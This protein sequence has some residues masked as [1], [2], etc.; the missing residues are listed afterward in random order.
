M[1]LLAVAVAW[2]STYW[3]AKE[4]VSQDTVLAVLAVRMLLTALALGVIL[5]AMRKRLKKTEAVVGGILGLL[6]STVFTFETFGIAAT[7]ATNA[8][9]IISLTVVM[10]PVLETVVSK[11]KLSRLFY[12]AAVIAVAGVY[13]L[14]TGGAAASFGFG[15]L[16]ILLA[17]VARA[18]HVTGMHRLSAGRRLDSLN[19]TFVQ[20]S[21]CGL[22]FLIMSSLWGIP[23]TT[24]A[25]SMTG[26]VLL[27]M[28][29]LVILC[30]VFPFFIQMWAVRKTSPTRVSLLLGTMWGQREELKTASR[31][32]RKR[33]SENPC[34]SETSR[35]CSGAHG[36]LRSS[37]ISQSLGNQVGVIGWPARRRQV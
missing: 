31:P 9:L 33:A 37:W 29:Y 27:Q 2:G 11:R 3:V 12:P 30:T 1:L 5:V 19:L 15:D 21:T 18:A 26:S 35:V 25:G 22:V 8:G 17:A 28:T 32:D 23:V 7:S 34:L 4:L 6:L 10:T 36:N 24:Y 14:A 13:F 16:L 20:M